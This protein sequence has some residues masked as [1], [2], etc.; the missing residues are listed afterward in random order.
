MFTYICLCSYNVIDHV[1]LNPGPCKK[2]PKCEELVPNRTINCKCGHVF[3]KCQCRKV[4][5]E[6]KRMATR[7]KRMCE[8]EN[9]VLVR[10]EMNRMS[11]CK[12][13][14]LETDDEAL[15]RK[16]VNR[17]CVKRKRLFETNDEALH[18]K[19]CE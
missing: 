1:E 19:R 5:V 6:I 11:M 15:H 18:R 2:C 12:K 13:R 4:R 17:L 9:D 3:R 7:S 10:N 8:S 14:L 16:D